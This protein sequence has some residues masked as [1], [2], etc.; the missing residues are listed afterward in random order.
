M[1]TKMELFPATNPNPVL[2]VSKDGTILYSNKGG[3]TLLH[4]WGVGVG[5]KLPPNVENIVHRVIF[6]NNPEK[7]EVKAGTRVYL[8]L[9]HSLQEGERVNIYGF[10]ISEQK[11]LEEK[12]RESEEKYRDIVETANEV[13]G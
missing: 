1:K 2:S 3:E 6:R 11:E 5:D 7:V 4:E 8:V 10:D 12:L 13:Y 9:F